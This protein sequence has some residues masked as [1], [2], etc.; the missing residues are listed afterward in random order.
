MFFVWYQILSLK[1]DLRRKDTSEA[2]EM[3][4]LKKMMDEKDAQ[5]QNLQGIR[6]ALEDANLKVLSS[7]SFPLLDIIIWWLWPHQLRE[8]LAAAQHHL[9]QQAA[10]NFFPASIERSSMPETGNFLR[11]TDPKDRELQ[12]S[13]SSEMPGS[14]KH[15]VTHINNR[16]ACSGAGDDQANGSESSYHSIGQ[17]RT[18]RAELAEARAAELRAAIAAN[19]NSKEERDRMRASTGYNILENSS[20]K[21]VD[22]LDG[23]EERLS[24]RSSGSKMAMAENR[25][26]ELAE[27]MRQ[28][29]VKVFVCLEQWI[30]SGAPSSSVQSKADAILFGA[31][32]HWQFVG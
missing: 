17:R 8:D 21:L 3:V 18:S 25:A 2:L 11:G 23:I 30:M 16:N 13:A 20:K 10:R 24:G 7:I 26:K 1:D 27:A 14:S 9:Q 6:E 22:T 29:Q 32:S 4:R 28:Q 5:I 19:S 31:I 15:G 12:Q